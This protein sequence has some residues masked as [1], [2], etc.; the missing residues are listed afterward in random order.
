MSSACSHFRSQIRH[1]P[2]DERAAEEKPE[3]HDCAKLMPCVQPAQQAE[4]EAYR[5][6]PRASRR[7]STILPHAQKLM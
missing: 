6:A 2:A 3:L 4:H 7:A 1:T 5:L